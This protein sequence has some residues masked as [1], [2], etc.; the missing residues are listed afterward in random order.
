M[1]SKEKEQAKKK[2]LPSRSKRVDYKL[3]NDGFGDEDHGSL[4]TEEHMEDIKLFSDCTTE[5]KQLEL[6]ILFNN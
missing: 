4:W 3:L 6:H 1:S 2:L 5:T